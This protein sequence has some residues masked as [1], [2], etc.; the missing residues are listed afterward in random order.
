LAQCEP[1]ADGGTTK[2]TSTLR[3]QRWENARAH[4]DAIIDLMEAMTSLP[5]P[6]VLGRPAFDAITTLLSTVP[7]PQEIT[8][9]ANRLAE[10]RRELPPELAFAVDAFAAIT[11]NYI[12]SVMQQ[13]QTDEWRKVARS[14][15]ARTI[16]NVLVDPI[17]HGIT[18]PE[19]NDQDRWDDYKLERGEPI[20]YRGMRVP[21][22]SRT[23][24]PGED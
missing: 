13:H 4:H 12:A 15:V 5:D 9:R 24:E 16:S 21:L 19:Q 8:D 2:I 18:T 7:H 10:V 20:N 1:D 22:P 6:A 11:L 23:Y 3:Q 17:G 14:E